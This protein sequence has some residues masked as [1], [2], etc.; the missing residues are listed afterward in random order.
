M[1]KKSLMKQVLYTFDIFYVININQNPTDIFLYE[2]MKV[3]AH[4]YTL[5]EY[6][7]E[8]GKWTATVLWD[9]QSALFYLFIYL[10]IYTG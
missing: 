10:N 8:I 2:S 6:I 1:K 7:Y 4:V 9:I 5:L 3:L